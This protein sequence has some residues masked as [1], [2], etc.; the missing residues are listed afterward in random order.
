MFR[1]SFNIHSFA[2][3]QS[4]SY[5]TPIIS[6]DGEVG[7]EN[8][9]PGF[10]SKWTISPHPITNN[11]IE[12]FHWNKKL[13]TNTESE[14][15]YQNVPQNSDASQVGL[16]DYLTTGIGSHEDL[17]LDHFSSVLASGFNVER[18]FLPSI[19]HGNIFIG[20]GE[21]YVFSDSSEIIFPTS[22][23]NDFPTF[24]LL[25][26]PKPS[27]PIMTSSYTWDEDERE[28]TRHSW[29]K[30]QSFTSLDDTV[31]VDSDTGMISWA[32]IDQSQREFII[33]T[34]GLT[35]GIRNNPEVILNQQCC[36]P[37]S[38]LTSGLNLSELE[39]LG[40]ST[41]SSDQSF[42][43]IYSPIDSG[44][45]VFVFSFLTNPG[46][47][48]PNES[49][50]SGLTGSG[51]TGGGVVPSFVI[52]GGSG[53]VTEWV[54]YIDTQ[55]VSGYSAFVDQKLGTITFHDQIPPAGEYIATHYWRTVELQ[56]EPQSTPDLCTL[57]I[58]TNPSYRE[59]NGGFLYLSSFERKPASISLRAE[60]PSISTDI[61]GPAQIGG[62]GVI[63]VA[64]VLDIHSAPI[65]SQIVE[66]FIDNS[67]G[68][69]NGNSSVEA[70]TDSNGEA[71]T[72]LLT[73]KSVD[74][75]SELVKHSSYSVNNTPS[76]P[77]VTQTTSL[78]ISTPVSMDSEIYVYQ[79]YT[80][81]STLGIIDH[82]VTSG[83]DIQ[84]NEYYTDYLTEHG[85]SGPTG[86]PI[87][88]YISGKSW[89]ELHREVHNFLEPVIFNESNGM[90]Q[91]VAV[92]DSSALDPHTFA[93]GAWVPIEPLDVVPSGTF[94]ELVFDT[95]VYT[96]DEPTG[97]ASPP[98]GNL[99]GYSIMSPGES[100]VHAT[101]DS[102][103]SNSISIVMS[104]PDYMN[105]T[106]ILNEINQVLIDEL[107][108]TLFS[109][110]AN[111]Q[112]IPLGWRLRSTNLTLAAAV[113]GV[114]FLDRN[115]LYNS[116]IWSDSVRSFQQKFEITSIV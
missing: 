108:S 107:S 15:W 70:L 116:D 114:T 102:A 89:E 72:I 69:F 75:I 12:G 3:I 58:N 74:D 60:L 86:I 22:S 2:S 10:H 59:S 97:S 28:Y 115:P 31:V 18:T 77:G 85:I 78:I 43:T 45:Q 110:A 61:Y 11:L 26:F 44:H 40:I 80:N 105:G 106:Y 79:V 38:S 63:L 27:T 73:P 64:T 19:I 1:Q 90:K 13:W 62:N 23:G 21:D 5:E 37:T 67:V 103:T 8:Y 92:W 41:G 39:I 42:H 111:G 95:S 82:S 20:S 16:E 33:T 65:E 81:D 113:G 55:L 34:S 56:Y 91:L 25:S 29:T 32:S 68:S 14:N 57:L 51:L 6:L 93:T 9:L 46:G 84:E 100:I 53:S 35:L 83:I 47:Y 48:I 98:V 101:A 4:V 54:P 88:D 109:I 50:V 71:R 94:R 76:Y 96:M 99:Y 7:G 112:K 87:S 17:R 36:F 24:E 104:I 49:L 52:H 30:K 66:F